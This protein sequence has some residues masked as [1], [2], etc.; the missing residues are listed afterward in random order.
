MRT[1][2]PL[3]A[4]LIC[5]PASAAI[6]KWVDENGKTQYSDKPPQQRTS[7]GETKLN[8][9]GMVV[10]KTEGLLTPEQ[11]AAK[12]KEQAKQREVAQK[13]LEARRRDKALL[14]S[15][16]NT[17]EIDA[18]LLRNVE[19]LQ[20]GIQSDKGRVE[21]AQKRLDG[22]LAKASK[23]NASNKPVSDDLRANIKD[24]QDDLTKI[25]EEI[26]RKEAEI[27]HLRQRADEDK[28]RFLELRGP[29]AK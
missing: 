1:H 8:N 17:S 22:F 27:A 6:Y 3:L 4:L 13:E 11:Q 23:A 19:Q 15:F 20:A 21:A 16:T 26:K 12:E 2:L 14:N 7:Q 28:K 5:L 29:G 24:R 25:Q 10:D 18:L 9:R